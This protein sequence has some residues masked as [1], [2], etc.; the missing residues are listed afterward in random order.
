MF[1]I[2]VCYL[3]DIEPKNAENGNEAV[4][5]WPQKI[6]LDIRISEQTV[7][8]DLNIRVFPLSNLTCN[9]FL[10]QP[11]T[12]DIRFRQAEDYPVDLYY[13]M[14]LSNSMEEDKDQVAKL[15]QEIGNGTFKQ[16]VAF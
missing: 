10:D 11:Q 9:S 16:P 3:K 14:D 6:D 12:I 1:Q 4:Q 2:L 15:G 5:L 7:F 8:V 13:L